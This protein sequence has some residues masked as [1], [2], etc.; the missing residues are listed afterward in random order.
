MSQSAWGNAETQFFFE[1]TPDKILDAVEASSGLRCTGRCLAL[2]SMENRVYEVELEIE[3]PSAL[4]SPSEKFRIAKFYRPG[5]WTEAQIL[6]EH[7]FLADLVENEIPA[8]APLPFKDGKTLHQ[9]DGVNIWY[10]IFPK[11]GGRSPD[12]LNEE[13][14]EQI[15]RLLGRMHNVGDSRPAPHRIQLNPATYGEANLKYLLDSNT[16][17]ADIRSQYQ[18]TVEGICQ[19]TTPWFNAAKV[20]RIHGDC[21][22]GNLI[23][24][25]DGAYFVDFDDMVRGPAVQDFWL[26]IP[27]RDEES[28]RKMNRLID[29]YEQMRPF[30]WET[31]RLVE[32][33]RALR[34]VHFSA[35]IAKRWHDPAFP[36]NFPQFGS[37]RY[38]QEQLSDLREQLGLIQ[39]ANG[40]F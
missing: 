11:I 9:V 20:H 40:N 31:L 12:E 16:L 38:W 2:N 32:P 21:H 6:E 26:M 17:P 13:Q 29:G 18:Q 22:L 10:T 28:Q 27:G 5:R 7:A 34:F 33:L 36:R 14:L 23:W 24:R 4:K 25:N 19:I 37:A 30:D 3:D 8:V 35:W 15:G 39:G 1:I